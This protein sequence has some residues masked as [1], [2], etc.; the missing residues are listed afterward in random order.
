MKNKKAFLITL[1]VL[2]CVSMFTFVACK[3][4]KNDGGEGGDGENS[5]ISFAQSSYSLV[6]GDEK[7]LDV[8]IS[9]QIDGASLAFSSSDS[10]VASVDSAS[11]TVTANAPGTA[12]ITATYGG[13]SATCSVSVGFGEYVP[14]LELPYVDG[15]TVNIDTKD[16]VN[17]AATVSFNGKTY[18][19]VE[20]SYSVADG[21]IGTVTDG[22]FTPSKAGTTDIT[23]SGKWYG[24]EGSTMSKT[25]TVNV[26]PVIEISI[27]GGIENEIIIY[28]GASY[29][30]EDDYELLTTGDTVSTPVIKVKED[31]E[32]LYFNVELTSG[33]DIV[34]FN[35]TTTVV[36]K[37]IVG[38]A[39]LTVYYTSKYDGTQG[40]KDIP[41]YVKP[42]LYKYIPPVDYF[43]ADDGNVKVGKKLFNILDDGI[44][45]IVSAVDSDG[46]EYD[47]SAGM[48]VYGIQVGSDKPTELELTVSGK[49]KGVV[50]DLKAYTK[51]IEDTAD[52]AEI[53]TQTEPPY[54]AENGF[55]GYYILANNIDASGYTHK[56]WNVTSETLSKYPTEDYPNS[57][58]TFTSAGVADVADK[59]LKAGLRGTFDGNGYTI[60]NMTIEVY[61]LFGWVNGGTVKNVAFTHVTLPKAASMVI[62]TSAVNAVI[63]N[64]YMQIDSVA[65]GASAGTVWRDSYKCE[66]T[67]VLIEYPDLTTDSSKTGS[68]GSLGTLYTQR[69]TVANQSA[70][71]N[72]YVIS[73]TILVRYKSTTA[74]YAADAQNRTD[75]GAP[76]TVNG[77]KRYNTV[78]SMKEDKDSNDYN[79][80][81]ESGFWTV[82]GDGELTWIDK[83]DGNTGG[84]EEKGPDF[85]YI[86]GKK[87]SALDGDLDAEELKEIF[88]EN[89][90]KLTSAV[91]YVFDKDRD[92]WL[93][94]NSLTVTGRKIKGV[95]PKLITGAGKI[96]DVGY[97]YVQLTNDASVTKTVRIKAY[98]KVIKKTSDLEKI[99]TQTEHPYTAE[100]GFDGYYILANNID[101]SGYTHK[102]WNTSGTT[103]GSMGI[104]NLA[105]KGYKSG[106][107]GTFD[108]NGYTISNMTMDEYGLFGW[109]NGGTVKNVAFT[110]VT[111]KTNYSRVIA[112]FVVNAVIE[113]VYMEVTNVNNLSG[114]VWFDTYKCEIANVLVKYDTYLSDDNRTGSYGSLGAIYTQRDTVTNQSA[115]T[116]VYVVSKTI[117]VRVKDSYKVDAENRTDTGATYTFKGVKRYDTVDSMKEDKASNDYSSFDKSDFWNVSDDGELT[118]VAKED[119]NS[120]D[121][122]DGPDYDFDYEEISSE[123]FSALDGDFDAEALKTIFGAS[124][125]V[126]LS[127]AKQYEFNEIADMWQAT[128]QLTVESG[129]INGVEPNYVKNSAGN[130]VG[131]DY[132]YLQLTS[133]SDTETVRIKAYTKVI[134]TTDDLA[135]IFIYNGDP[136]TTAGHGFDGY[137]ILAKNIDA[138][139]YTHTVTTNAYNFNEPGAEKVVTAGYTAGLRGTFDGNGY[140]ISNIT[141]AGCGLFGWVNG[142]TVKN[143]AFTDVKFSVNSSMVIATYVV[144]AVIENVYME[145]K[146][147]DSTT[148]ANAGSVWSDTYKSEIT[149]VLVKYP[150]I[151]EY[152]TKTGSYGSLGTLWVQR[153]TVANHSKYTNVYVVSKTILAKVGSSYTVDAENLVT[154]EQLSGTVYRFEGVKRYNDESEMKSAGISY[155]SSLTESDLWSVED[156]VLTWVGNGS[157]N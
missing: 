93:A 94:T 128:K 122:E 126:T 29:D 14:M 157:N 112:Q 80:F 123:L 151:S 143:V 78:D 23:V 141:M 4:N 44:D 51:V 118:W 135:K 99:F 144:N 39:T 125:T 11:G 76:H 70:Y 146:S 120:G 150:D 79:S 69:N 90:V 38:K 12:T 1:V 103:Y 130:V 62:A 56:I 104:T 37:G 28:T 142:G 52:L 92:M 139:D 81:E 149:N 110:N 137:Y 134:K 53:F 25:V 124:D 72:V 55:D 58:S 66:I 33:S 73:P 42:S 100:Y 82:S 116:N 64:V 115:Y 107:T 63:E 96:T 24:Y 140:T 59:D 17:L 105:D 84:A 8:T 48:L 46:N 36:G 108:G 40:R 3:K 114:T 109:V 45:G 57:G 155:E 60:S 5:S 21:S 132:I 54:Y 31:G 74:E 136:R 154:E 30:N 138:T 2:L 10:S 121:V 156:G 129:K 9:Q 113:N 95:E 98:T 152:T 26:S 49:T 47:V 86:Y 111:L 43:S 148:N 127:S 101:A 18:T 35:N 67:N 119:E 16:F 106:L 65:S 27:N 153:K 75:T 88:G 34:D 133:G 6:I 102:V 83:E 20:I 77:V 7:E 68:Y 19:N 91:Q 22:K 145:I 61:G 15:D 87:F 89:R 117:L 13:N 131:V 97:V 50:I 41:I 85:D 147:L 32:E 71:R